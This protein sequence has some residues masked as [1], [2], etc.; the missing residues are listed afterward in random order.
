MK[1]HLSPS[2]DGDL[3]PFQWCCTDSPLCHLYLKKRPLDRCQGYSWDRADGHTTKGAKT[4]QG[5]AMVFGSLHFHTFDGTEYTFKALG[6]FVLLRLS[7]VTGSNVF[8]LQGQ[9]DRLHV[10]TGGPMEVPVVVRLA[11]FHQGIGKIELRSA[12]N[13]EGLQMF[14]DDVEVPVT[15]EV[16]RQPNK[17][18]A[19]RCVSVKRCVVVYAGGL[20][21]LAWRVDGSNQLGAIVGVPQTF[22]NHTVGLMGHW[23]SNHSNDF[24]M[25]DGVILPS[26]DTPPPE[27]EIQLFGLSWAVPDPESLL[28]SPPPLEPL[29]PVSSQDLLSSVSP[30]EVEEMRRSCK[31]NMLCVL[32]TVATGSPEL[33]QNTLMADIDYSKMAQVYG[34]MPPIVTEPTMIRCK[35]NSALR[36][37]IVAKDPNG[38]PITFS[39]LYP[40]PP[41]ASIGGSDGFLL[42]TPV[43]TQPVHLTLKVSDD[44][45]SSLFT[46]ILRICS[47]LNGGTCQYDSVIENHLK[48]KFQ[49]VG[50][51]C[52]PGFSGKFCGNSSNI[53]RGQPC[54][55]G[56]DCF[57]QTQPDAFTCGECPEN[58]VS[59]G[60]QGYKC[61][62]HDMCLPP[63]PFPC[64]E[65]ADCVSTKQNYTCSCKSGYEGDGV[66]CSDIDECADLS[67]CQNA[68]FECKNTPG[69]VECICRYKDSNGCGDSAN[70][71][72]SNLFNVSVN[73]KDTR[74]DGLKQLEDI[75][76]MGFQNKFYNA[77]KKVSGPGSTQ[78]VEYRV[79]MS[80]DTPHWY[81][82]DYMARVSNHYGINS[83]SVDDVDECQS[84]EAQ[85]VP[86]AQC[87][88]TYGG[89]RCLC[90]GTDMDE[91]QSCVLEQ[92]QTGKPRLD[93]IL[94]LVLGLGIPL[95]L[96]LLLALLACCYCCCKK[97]K[98]TEDV[99]HLLPNH[100]QN[101]YSPPPPF[102]Y[103]DP[104]L[105]YISH[106]SPRIIDNIKPRQRPR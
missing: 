66:S 20:N 41:G 30:A 36:V 71:P 84:M 6:E 79:N 33:G 75:L 67:T 12:Q 70:P 10:G 80:S 63:F 24:L 49:V 90:N 47:C 103:S 5:V 53:C 77:S 1:P 56:V 57:P 17:D 102:N 73:W 19:V 18:F 38:D 29:Q 52:P 40:R 99:P 55:R 35:V 94:G 13:N 37:Q 100:V 93:L 97:K 76:K 26:A 68:K 86:P 83:I 62:E 42:W 74:P 101:H 96:L 78:A 27:E 88:N 28:F 54:F 61:F 82:R 72:G 48:G 44:R 16:L 4:T 22:Y 23:S 25:S 58:T 60:Q 31:G 105:R 81:V 21:V 15:T 11:A 104:S 34:N 85:C 87:T 3:L 98:T 2:P 64:H 32:D 46:P 92:H 95:L 9:T 39:M 89:Y 43:S 51:L 91:S 45:S 69:S 50:C 7:T 65:D 8:T 59:S 106:C 14:V